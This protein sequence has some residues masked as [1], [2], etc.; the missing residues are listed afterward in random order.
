MPRN[1]TDWMKAPGL[2]QDLDLRVELPVA[3]AFKVEFFNVPGHGGPLQCS[4]QEVSGMEQT[5]ETEE[6]PEGG[7]NRY[8]HQLPTR[9]KAKRLTLRRGLVDRGSPFVAWCRRSLQGGM[10]VP[11]Q[12]V[13]V[14]V[15]LFGQLNQPLLVWSCNGAFPV[16]WNIDSFESTKNE[17]AIEEIEL[18]YRNCVSPS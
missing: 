6:V 11:L 8:V 16:R 12:L 4:F 1:A 2:A 5:L 17:A 7:E 3:F 9:A 10:E 14:K 15:Q 13:D 18:A